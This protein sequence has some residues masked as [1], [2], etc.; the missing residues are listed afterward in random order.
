MRIRW[1][2]RNLGTPTEKV[3][4]FLDHVLKPVMQQSRSYIKD[5]NYT[6]KKL[7]KIKW[8][9][10][11]AIMV[12]ADV[13]GPKDSIMVTADVV[14]VVMSKLALRTLLKWQDLF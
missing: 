10:K 12:T 14:G 13:V 5:S 2:F 7:E 9:P 1:Y 3:L 6:I 4:Q 8:V 11:D